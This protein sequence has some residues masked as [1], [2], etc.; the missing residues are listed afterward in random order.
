MQLGCL[1]NSKQAKALQNF[2]IERCVLANYKSTKPE[3]S[4]IIFGFCC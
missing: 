1:G 2:D 4:G 3:K